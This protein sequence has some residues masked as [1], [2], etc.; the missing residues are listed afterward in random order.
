MRL[1]SKQRFTILSSVSK[2]YNTVFTQDND[3]FSSFYVRLNGQVAVCNWPKAQEREVL[4]VPFLGRIRDIDVQHQLIRLKANLYGTFK[5]ALKCEKRANTSAQFQKLLPQLLSSGV[6]K[7]K[8]ESAFSIQSGKDNSGGHVDQK[9][10]TFAKIRTASHVIFAAKPTLLNKKKLVQ[11]RR[12]PVNFVK[13]KE[14]SLSA[15]ICQKKGQPSSGR[16]GNF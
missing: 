15:V 6:V 1:S 11:R 5:L 16:R 8:H 4:K 12:P 10:L 9:N 13:S 7:L 3:T 14:T 2:L